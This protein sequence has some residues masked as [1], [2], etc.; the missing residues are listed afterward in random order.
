M[1][2]PADHIVGARRLIDVCF[3]VLCREVDRRVAAGGGDCA[4]RR[5]TLQVIHDVLPGVGD[6][7]WE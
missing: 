3:G 5:V 2:P 7:T 4:C 1:L 6:L